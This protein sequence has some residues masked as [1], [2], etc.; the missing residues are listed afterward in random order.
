MK[1]RS[2]KD[3]RQPESLKTDVGHKKGLVQS[4]Q[5]F[6]LKGSLKSLETAFSGCFGLCRL[7]E[8][9]LVAVGLHMNRTFRRIAAF[10]QRFGQRVFDFGLNRAF[11]RARAV[12]GV[13]TGLGD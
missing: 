3:C 2:G 9:Q 6:G 12:H 11:E 7:G 5:S 8:T 13:E 1:E 10:E 4:N